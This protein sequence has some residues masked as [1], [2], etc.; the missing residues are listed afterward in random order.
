MMNSRKTP[1]L[2]GVMT[3]FSTTDGALYLLDEKTGYASY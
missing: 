1:V 3:D 2:T